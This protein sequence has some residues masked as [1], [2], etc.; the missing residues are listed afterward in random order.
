MWALHDVMNKYTAFD[1]ELRVCRRCESI[2]VAISV[3]PSVSTAC[4]EPRP[5][6]S[7]IRSKPILLI[8]QA[9]GMTEYE[10]RK[11]FQ[12]PAGQKIREIFREAGV[13][14]FDDSAP[15]KSR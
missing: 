8:G 4:V 6:V 15:R 1:S 2:L 13:A 10:T 7:G 5:I 9:P 14:D 3:D 11:P 12:G